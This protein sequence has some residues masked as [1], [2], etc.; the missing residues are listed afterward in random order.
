[1]LRNNSAQP[2]PES[3]EYVSLC[4]CWRINPCLLCSFTESCF[5]A[6][7]GKKSTGAACG[8][9]EIDT[10]NTKLHGPR[11]WQSTSGA[12][13]AEGVEREGR[14]DCSPTRITILVSATSFMT[15]LSD[16]QYC[17]FYRCSLLEII[18]QPSETEASSTLEP[19]L[20]ITHN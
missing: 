15:C 6:L 19:A 3:V 4:C 10:E 20:T 5:Q 11:H 13:V 12:N 7:Q 2:Y 14:A 8:L 17:E 9:T 16:V 1:M 18:C